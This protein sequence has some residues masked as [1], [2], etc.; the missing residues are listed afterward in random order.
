MNI[1]EKLAEAVAK[2]GSGKKD[3][4][5]KLAEAT[6]ESILKAIENEKPFAQNNFRVGDLITQVI[7]NEK[8]PCGH[9]SERDYRYKFPVPGQPAKVVAVQNNAIYSDDKYQLTRE[10]LVIRL[11]NGNHIRDYCV[12]SSAFRLWVEGEQIDEAVK[13]DLLK[14]A[15]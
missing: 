15:E 9:C 13:N 3:Q 1:D 4:A 12:D 7:R 8:C 2:L 10:D 11:F 5:K 14:E 6:S